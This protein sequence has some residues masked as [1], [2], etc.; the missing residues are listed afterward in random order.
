MA[1]L[2]FEGNSKAMFDRLVEE[3]PKPFRKN[4]EKK[5][6]ASFEQK[7]GE[8]GIVTEDI[9]FQTVNEITPKPFLKMT[10]KILEE[11]KS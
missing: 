6:R 5:I 2:K 9:V 7:A 4:N 1:E 3:S 11:M 10:L 8:S